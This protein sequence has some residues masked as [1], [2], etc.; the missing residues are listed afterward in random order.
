MNRPDGLEYWHMLHSIIDSET[1]EECDRIMLGTLAAIGIER[2]NSFGQLGAMYGSKPGF[3]LLVGP[4]WK[5]EK[6]KGFQAVLLSPTVV[7]GVFP[8]VFVDDVAADHQAIQPLINQI[9]AYPLSKFTGK[10]QTR[11]WSKL[12][13]I[14]TKI[15]GATETKWVLSDTF[16]AQLP[17]VLDEV[18]P[19]PGEEAIYAQVRTLLQT[20]QT[21]PKI[22]EAL[23]K[24]ARDTEINLIAPCSVG[25]PRGFRSPTAGPRWRTARSGA[26]TT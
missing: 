10:V 8:R 7:G 25:A 1:I 4:D 18:P 21:N 26:A 6:P 17:K 24:V 5:G 9:N 23:K 19:M 3:Y 11:D 20:A 13:V 22:M 16:F 15:E 14:P 12:P 2:T